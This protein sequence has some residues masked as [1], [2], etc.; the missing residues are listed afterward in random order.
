MGW[1]RA[2]TIAQIS[3]LYVTD[4]LLP[5]GLSESMLCRW[6]HAP[7]D[8]PG[9]DYAVMLCRAYRAQPGQLGLHQVARV[10]QLSAWTADM[11]K[12]GRND[13]DVAA[14]GR[15]E[16]ADPMTTDAGLPSVRESLQLALLAARATRWS[17]NSPKPRPTTTR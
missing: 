12:Y 17:T 5:P 15:Q 9:Q 7:E 8:W 3:E 2:D 1:S 11:I 6:E 13:A 4:G 16:G 10:R 14:S